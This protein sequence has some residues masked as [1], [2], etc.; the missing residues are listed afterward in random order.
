MV[1]NPIGTERE[2]STVPSVYISSKWFLPLTFTST[3][4]RVLAP[5]IPS[6]LSPKVYEQPSE[7]PQ[8]IHL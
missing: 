4:I 2:K 6:Q 8:F 5:T 1:F 7:L 3:I